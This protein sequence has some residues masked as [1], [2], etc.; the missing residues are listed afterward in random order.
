LVYIPELDFFVARHLSFSGRE[1][2]FLPKNI[3]SEKMIMKN[4]RRIFLKSPLLT[5]AIVCFMLA[6]VFVLF[7]SLSSK[8][9]VNR[10][11]KKSAIV[12]NAQMTPSPTE[13]H[14]YSSKPA[15][16]TIPSKQQQVLPTPNTSTNVSSPT[17]IPTQQILPT[18]ATVALQVQL[19]INGSL[20]GSITVDLGSTQCDVLMKAQ[21]QGKISRL[22]MKY[23]NGLGTNAVYQING[24]G[25]ENAV[26]WVYKVN[27]Q[28][29][30]QGCSFIK[31]NNGDAVEWE[32]KG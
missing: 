9:E 20:A 28:S 11:A 4:V 16:S 17:T 29:P 13:Q 18:A 7:P 22:L 30:T 27:G 2:F 31:V 15:I 8:Q 25:K 21:E 5:V 14:F 1:G 19:S 6:G 32:Y 3:L 10:I 26:W 12:K 23:D 24:I